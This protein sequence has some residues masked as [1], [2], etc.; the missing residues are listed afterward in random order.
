MI[1]GH[2]HHRRHLAQATVSSRA[3]WG[4]LANG[5]PLTKQEISTYNTNVRQ[6]ILANHAVSRASRDLERAFRFGPMSDLSCHALTRLLTSL[7]RWLLYKYSKEGTL[8]YFD[9][10]QSVLVVLNNELSQYGYTRC[11]EWEWLGPTG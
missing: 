7:R 5:R 2:Y 10:T 4:L 3:G 6:A 11:G 1:P 8:S 9:R